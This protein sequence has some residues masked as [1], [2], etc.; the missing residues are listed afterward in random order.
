MNGFKLLGGFGN[1]LT[2]G[3]TNERTLVVVCRVAFAT[4]K[5]D[6]ELFSKKNGLKQLSIFCLPIC[7]PPRIVLNMVM[8][9]M[10]IDDY[11]YC[12]F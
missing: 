12:D 10:F 6:L 1:R 3:R 2:D 9:V 5:T 7:Q 4:D 11:A 8:L